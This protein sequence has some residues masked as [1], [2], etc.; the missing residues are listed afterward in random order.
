MRIQNSTGNV[1]IGTGN[2][3]VRLDVVPAAG[4]HGIRSTASGAGYGILGYASGTGIAVYGSQTGSS[5][6][7]MGQANGAGIAVYGS[8]ASN[9][10]HAA[11]FL[12]TS[13]N[14]YC[15]IGHTSLYSIVCSGPTSLPSDMRLKKD[16]TSLTAT[17]GLSAIMDLHPISYTWKD[18]KKGSR[19]EFGFVAQEVEKVFPNLVGS[20]TPTTDEEKAQTGGEP[21]KTLQYEGFIAPLVK[22]VQELKGENDMLKARIEK[23]ESLLGNK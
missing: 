21:M 23:L 19:T 2:P 16:I 15:Y 12:N 11:L 20:L 8:Q 10:G 7:V 9:T 4:A 14:Y 18:S 13:S 3:G 5:H 17:S 1:G 22:S 6:A